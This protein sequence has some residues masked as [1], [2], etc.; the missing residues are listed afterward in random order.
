MSLEKLA[1]TSQ[2]SLDPAVSSGAGSPPGDDRVERAAGALGVEFNDPELLRLALVHSSYLNEQEEDGLER[3]EESNERLEFLGDAVLG[4]LVADYMYRRHPDM[5]EGELTVSRV[6]LVRRET[7]AQWA[8]EFGLDEVL[9]IARGEF[10]SRGKL[11]DRIL[12][13]VFEAVLGAI[14]LDQGIE[15]TREFL[16]RLLDRDAKK[17]L[18]KRDLT[19]Y[20]GQLQETLQELDQSTPEYEVV[21]IKGPAHNRYFTV[22]ALHDRRVIGEGGGRTKRAAEQA[23]AKDALERM[24]WD[25]P[26]P[27]EA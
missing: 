27:D 12:S 7:L 1:P 26:E 18:V 24:H 8:R 16:E 10:R 22:R 21:E 23:A 25:E 6:S 5:A 20:K 17:I 11:G 15:K 4:F 3:F 19:N 13:G 9:Y 14:Y 2:A